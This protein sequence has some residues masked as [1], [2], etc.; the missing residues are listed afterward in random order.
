VIPARD[1]QLPPDPEAYR[2][3]AHPHGRVIVIAPT[4][5]ACE[6]IELAMGL[7]LDTVLEREHGG[8]LRRWAEQGIGF[9]II[10]GTGTGKTLGIRP[11]AESILRSPLRVGVVNR[12]REATPETPGWNVVIVT[13]GIARRWFQD[14]LITGRDTIVADEIHQTSAELELC[15]ALGKRAGCRFIWLS[16][17][18]DPAFYARYLKSTEV[19]ETS[20]FDP[21][22]RAKVRVLAQ[23]PGEFL[24]D[25]YIRHLI[26]EKRGVAVFVPTRAEVEKLAQ[27][28][29]ERWPRL[30]A[31]FYHGGEPI[32]VIRPFLEGEVEHPFLLAMTAAGQ[33]ALNV[34]GLDTVVIFDAR[35]GN[36]V[37]RGRN[38]LHR[39][40]LGANE[41]LQMAGRVHGRVANGEVVILTDR[42]LVFE[43]LKPT[44]P[45]F[46][47][48]GDAERVAI[49]CAA[50][51]VDAQDLEL[52]VP[53][54]RTAYRKAVDLLNSRGI[55]EN[56]RLTGYGRRVEALPVERPWGELLV[57]ADT[58]LVPVIAVASSIESLHRMT[59]E[60][61]ELHGVIVNGSD[62]LTAYNLY[63]EA[64]N[65]YGSMGSVYGLPRHVFEEGLEEWAEKR[66]VLIKAIEDTALG[67]A[68]VYRSLDLDLPLRLPHATKDVHRRF[69]EL[70]A[71]IMPFDLVI[72]EHTADGQE[73]RVS[74]SSVAGSWG[75]VAGSLRY[76]A[77]RMGIPRAGI[78]GTTIPYDL[79]RENAQWAAPTVALSTRRKDQH[80]V[81]HRRLSYFG[82]ELDTEVEIIEGSF[83]QPLRE[84]AKDALAD[85]LM[86]GE[87]M[88]SDQ[89]KVRRALE[90]LGELWRR[91]GGTLPQISGGA[92]RQ[93]IRDQLREVE[94]WEEFLQ[95]R[96]SLNPIELVHEHVREALQQLPSMIRIKGDA[97]ALD[98]AIEDSAGVVRLRLREGQAHQLQERDV[99]ELDRPVRF[100]VVRGGEEAIRAATLPELKAKLKG[101]GGKKHE[102][103]KPHSKQRHQRRGRH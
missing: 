23:E 1:H 96:V 17:T 56:G 34:R 69:R 29:G 88:H 41:I 46:Q 52:P 72:D 37:D 57:H 61:R 102:L 65:Q 53:L 35:Y 71:R 31:A 77:D 25:K 62:H 18:V 19:L 33:S 36:V 11:I 26:K 8:D 21:A 12:E 20:A 30:N 92:L 10:A 66:G 76:F 55:I 5:A 6:T 7:H 27:S 93:R 74:R 67:V 60:E 75:G 54:D 94:S 64:V 91:S 95:T 58:E 97:V 63:A 16:A 50:I 84:L 28:L 79:I 86:A 38:V 40:H 80:L 3:A 103:R 14:D 70:V 78:E 51:G 59:R 42:R 85:A 47:L 68:S 49:T 24:D 2:K 100:T 73:A 83:P 9:G 22:L 15:L 48:A 89:G 45:E 98:Y 90:E 99:P 32:R 82:F 44:P 43:Q 81:T 4:R 39:L 87:T 13:T 101:L